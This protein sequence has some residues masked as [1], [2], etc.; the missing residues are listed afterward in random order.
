MIAQYFNDLKHEFKGY[1][2]QKFSKDLMAGLTVMAVALPLAVAFGV[3]SGAGAASGMISAILAGI[4]IGG[5]SGGSYQVSGPTGTMSA[6]L[7]LLSATY[8][9][10]SVFITGVLSGVF[11]LVA[12]K[13][14]F[15]K[16][17]SFIP[18]HV[19]TGF[20]SGVALIILRGQIKN[21]F[22]ITQSSN[23][24]IF[25]ILTAVS[26]ILI[27]IIWPKKLNSKIPSS[28]AAV[29]IALVVSML[30]KI[31]VEVVGNIPKTL[32]PDIR[33]NIMNIKIT[34]VINYISPAISISILILIESLLC[35]QSA[36]KIKNEKLNYDRELL[37]QG[38][39]NI[40]IPFFGGIPASAVLARTSVSIKSGGQTRLVGFVQSVA[41]ILAMFL[42]SP[43]IAQIPM[44]ALAGVL[45]VTA[46]RM[47]EWDEIKYIFSKKFGISIVQFLVTMTATVMFNLTIAILVG[48]TLSILHFVF[49]T[50]SLNVDISD[51]DVDRV[52]PE[53]KHHYELTKIVYLTGPL[54]FVTKD[55]LGQALEGTYDSRNI[56]FSMRAVTAVDESAVNDF[57]EI[58]QKYKENGTNVLFCGVQKN[59]KE[60]FDQ[61][62]LTKIIKN[63]NFYWDALGAM[64]AIESQSIV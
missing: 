12:A 38:V 56:I 40:V 46:W 57:I 35:G 41:L 44:P 2:L 21:F 42:L 20:T 4:I 43:F 63:K 53:N 45:I 27:M 7:A 64:K 11:L 37:A 13:F 54:F 19:A 36:G 8:G 14:N 48:L 47:N 5:L 18:T 28:L 17:V 52:S 24:N 3:S 25:A 60:I 26:V 58:I 29:I 23:F 1:N 33:L 49:K 32:M 50:S 61:S 59:V 34:E 15:G 51:I 31:P 30:T 62:G 6:I 55:K 10:N 16:F 9:V 39:G 22:G